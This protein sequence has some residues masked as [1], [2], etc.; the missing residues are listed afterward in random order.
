VL[1]NMDSGEYDGKAADIWSCGVILYVMLFGRCGWHGRQLVQ[2]CA[3]QQRPR[4]RR[5]WRAR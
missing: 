3:L 5:G 1:R 2:R 4:R